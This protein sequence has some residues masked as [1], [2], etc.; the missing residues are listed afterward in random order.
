MVVHLLH[1]IGREDDQL[2][3]A[4][5]AALDGLEVIALRRLNGTQTGPAALAIDDQARQLGACQITDT[6]G[7][8]RNTG[9]GRRCHD[10]L[11]GR[12]T[13]V[14]HIDGRNLGLGLQDDHAGGLPR[15]QL[16]QSLHHLGL[17]RNGVTEITVAAV[18]D[19][20]MGNHLVALH[21]LH[22]FLCHSPTRI[23]DDKP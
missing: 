17:R 7:H 6:L 21:Q 10:A 14:D 1:G 23:F 3:I 19:G 8:Q 11:T 5:A 9:A 18:T 2:V 20:G 4:V 13:A 15:L 22:L 16:H 12:S